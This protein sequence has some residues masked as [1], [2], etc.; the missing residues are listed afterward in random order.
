M[1]SQKLTWILLHS[2]I[3]DAHVK[4]VDLMG[5]VSF[6]RPLD[7]CGYYGSL[8]DILPTSGIT[9]FIMLSF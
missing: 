4:S 2:K 3:T 5:L 6:G 7:L 9:Y 1:H 8:A